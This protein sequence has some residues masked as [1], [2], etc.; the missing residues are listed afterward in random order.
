MRRHV[1]VLLSKDE[2]RRIARDHCLRNGFDIDVFEELVDAE[3]EQIG[4]KRK[5]GLWKRFDDIIDQ[6]EAERADVSEKNRS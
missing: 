3:L 5:A 2:G 1:V 6:M 4:K